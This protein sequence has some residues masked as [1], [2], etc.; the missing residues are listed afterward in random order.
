[1]LSVDLSS[2]GIRRAALGLGLFFLVWGAA[3]PAAAEDAA[4]ASP[5]LPAPRLVI[6]A[7]VFEGGEFPPGAAFTHEFVIRNEGQAPLTI[8]EAQAGCSC[9]VVRYD[10]TI[11][12]GGSGRVAVTIDVY[13]EWAGR[14]LRRTFWLISNDPAVGQ[15]PLVVRGR[16]AGREA[17]SGP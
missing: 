6:D 9:A 1:M 14:E 11:S 17:L 16:V 12:P 7:P 10:R 3:G 5:D 15:F 8:E 2:S 13:R 4:P